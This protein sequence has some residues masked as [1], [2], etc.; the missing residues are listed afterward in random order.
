MEP[1]IFDSLSVIIVNDYNLEYRDK[2]KSPKITIDF[3]NE[4]CRGLNYNF[5]KTIIVFFI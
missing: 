1:L 5:L 2:L 4:L 3:F